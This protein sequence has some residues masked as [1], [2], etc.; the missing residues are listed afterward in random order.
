[1]PE[2]EVDVVGAG[3]ISAEKRPRA[4]PVGLCGVGITEIF[5]R[6]FKHTGGQ[7]RRADS[8]RGVVAHFVGRW[9]RDLREAGF[10]VPAKFDH[11][12]ARRTV[13]SMLRDTRRPASQCVT[14]VRATC[15]SFASAA[16]VMP[17]FLRRFLS[18]R[19]GMP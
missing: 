17:R 2:D 8:M 9:E 13:R 6:V 18:A 16:W 12:T 5:E 11:F 19:F 4:V 7:G 1:M 3:G 10:R 14:V 15:A